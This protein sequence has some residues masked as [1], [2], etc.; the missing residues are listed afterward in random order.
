MRLLSLVSLVALA[1]CRKD[2][3]DFV[4]KTDTALPADDTAD[5]TDDTDDTYDTDDTD[6]DT[7]DDTAHLPSME[8]PAEF[9]RALSEFLEQN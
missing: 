4:P 3:D 1:A 9:N 8:R 7:V 2:P 5:D 6:T